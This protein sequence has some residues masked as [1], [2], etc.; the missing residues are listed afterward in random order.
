MDRNLKE[1]SEL[2]S[3]KSPQKEGR[4]SA[5]SLRPAHACPGDSRRLEWWLR[6]GERWWVRTVDR[7][8]W[9]ADHRVSALRTL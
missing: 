4:A 2:D 6:G 7:L 3:K 1:V 9:Q 8:G 5:T